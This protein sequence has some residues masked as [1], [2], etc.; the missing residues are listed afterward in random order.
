MTN[1]KRTRES[2]STRTHAPSAVANAG[3]GGSPCAKRYRRPARAARLSKIEIT[4]RLRRLVALYD[5]LGSFFFRSRLK[6]KTARPGTSVSEK[7]CN[8]ARRAIVV[9]TFFFCKPRRGRRLSASL[10]EPTTS[11]LPRTIIATRFAHYA[12][13]RENAFERAFYPAAR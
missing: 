9:A 2:M 10:R 1:C 6:K 12:R 4:D 11:A 3:I 5:S 8:Y 7:P 13:A